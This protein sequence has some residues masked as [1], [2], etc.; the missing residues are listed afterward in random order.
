[1]RPEYIYAVCPEC[2]VPARSKVAADPARWSALRPLLKNTV[3][4]CPLCGRIIVLAHATLV[5]HNATGV[6]GNNPIV[7]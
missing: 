6:P 2:H 7:H 1:M 5:S 3:A 4:C